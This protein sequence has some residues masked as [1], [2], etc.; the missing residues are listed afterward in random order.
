MAYRGAVAA[1][2]VEVSP[3]I[4]YEADNFYHPPFAFGTVG[5]FAFDTFDGGGGGGP[6]PIPTTGQ[7]WP[8]G[9]Y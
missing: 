5:K 7:T 4:E 1:P 9:N 3:L 6:A 2:I 8:R